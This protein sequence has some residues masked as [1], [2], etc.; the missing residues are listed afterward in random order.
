MSVETGVFKVRERKSTDK[1]MEFKKYDP[2][3]RKHVAFLEKK[4]K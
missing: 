3:L 2:V 4:I 1:K